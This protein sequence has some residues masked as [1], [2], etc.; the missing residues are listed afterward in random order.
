[1][2]ATRRAEK[3]MAV[4]NRTGKYPQLTPLVISIFPSIY[5][6][7]YGLHL[8]FI[9]FFSFVFQNQIDKKPTHK[10]CTRLLHIQN[11]KRK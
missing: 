2:L 3:A 10:K 1:M 6:F 8:G 4:Q 9:L 5:H 11:K 7:M